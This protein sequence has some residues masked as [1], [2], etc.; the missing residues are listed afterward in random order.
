MKKSALILIALLTVCF[1]ASARQISE[2]EAMLKAAA[3]GQKAVAS[4]LM[5]N[6]RTSAITLAYTQ[7]SATSA[8]DN[9]FYVF[10]RGTADGYIIVSADD[11]TDAILGYTD[12]GSFDYASLPAN[13]R[14]WF[15]TYQH[16]I[17]YLIDHPNFKNRIVPK[18]L[19]TSVTP[20]CKSLW[21]QDSPFNDSCPTYTDPIE[22]V[23]HC[24]TGCVATAMAQ[25]MYYHKW[26]LKG[27][28]SNSYTSHG[29]ENGDSLIYN[30]SADFSKSTYDWANMTDRYN[31]ASTTAQNKAVAKLMSDVGISV[32]MIYGSM[33][34][35]DV[36][37][38]AYA[39]TNFF[40][41][42]QS[43]SVLDRQFVG[44]DEWENYIRGEIN[45]K[46]PVL[47]VGF[48]TQDGHAFVCDGYSSDDFF[49][50]N[51]G[52]SGKSNGYFKI[53]VLTPPYLGIGGGLGLGFNDQQFIFVNLTTPSAGTGLH[54]I[55][56]LAYDSISTVN[57]SVPLGGKLNIFVSSLTNINYKPF[58]GS[59]A[60]VTR[61]NN[62]TIVDN[63]P[64]LTLTGDGLKMDEQLQIDGYETYTVPSSL[65][66]GVYTMD[67][68]SQLAGD[69]LWQ[70]AHGLVGSVS[71]FAVNVANGN[72]SVVSSP[73]GS[74]FV[75]S[76][77]SYY[78]GLY[79]GHLSDISLTIYNTG[80]DYFGNIY[81]VGLD[82]TGN[83]IIKAQNKFDIPAGKSIPIS[84]RVPIDVAAQP[85]SLI[86]LDK[87]SA[88]FLFE[89][90]KIID[91]QSKPA[92]ALTSLISFPDKN[93]VDPYNLQL[94]ASVTNTGGPFTG[95]IYAVFYDADGN[96]LT[97]R[98]P[99][100]L[101]GQNDTTNI[102]YTD[103]F[104]NGVQGDSYSV[105]LCT[106]DENGNF[107]PLTPDKF[108]NI[109]FTINATP[110]S[111]GSVGTSAN[112]IFPNPA[113]DAVTVRNA[114]AISGIS[115]YSVTGALV[116]SKAVSGQNSVTLNVAQLPA[117]SYIVR[118]ANSAGITTQ[119][120]IKK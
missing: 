88:A 108:N 86:F 118:V 76:D 83:E 85:A 61:D 32:N 41:Y 15:S 46:R 119:R 44:I 78:P 29:F 13:A 101:I 100:I 90:V 106:K 43:L 69:N 23:V 97:N 116:L 39:F 65:S 10:N 82:S 104:A 105:V 21:N 77:P 89:N 103:G 120:F 30:L 117:G 113:A 19:P 11:R 37:P 87:D 84:F 7:Q 79:A 56:G 18:S 81:I 36:E 45:S 75:T 67:I 28:G 47:Y 8:A 55:S 40:G 34:G 112:N 74:K 63:Q 42:D 51:W 49:H 60:L 58:L 80:A 26:P 99:N 24:A 62:G 35:S 73:C 33:S 91:A 16:Q 3:F 6:S 25:V 9:C 12:S 52:W 115:V 94:S 50:F 14:W 31:S 70:H 17:Q 102:T 54:Y 72:A 93:N 92:L 27:T 64:F 22:G 53:N 110:T 109:S 107:V 95:K 71:K 48:S 20:I 114:N 4:R 68:E 1:A 111:I 98:A 38:T 59:V 66:D 2:N 57:A 5:S 96:L